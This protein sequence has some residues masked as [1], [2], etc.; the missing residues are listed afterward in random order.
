MPRYFSPNPVTVAITHSF[1]SPGLLSACSLCLCYDEVTRR[2]QGEPQ[3]GRGQD[4]LCGGVDQAIALLR[5]RG[6]L[7]YRTLQLQFQLDDAYLAAL[8]DELIEGQRLAVDEAGGPG[9]VGDT[10]TPASPAAVQAPPRAASAPPDAE[11][12]QLTVL[13]CDLVDSTAPVQPARP[14]RPARWS[15]PIKTPAPRSS[16]A[17]RAISRSTSAMACGLLRVPPGAR[18]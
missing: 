3:G 6:R 10:A 14:G 16:P 1:P 8:T 11:R 15:G 9:L 17:T 7:K 4:G 12:L 5:Q 13:F 2:T 18:R